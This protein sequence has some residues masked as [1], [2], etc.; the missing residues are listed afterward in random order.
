MSKKNWERVAGATY[1][2]LGGG[3]LYL[4]P[5]DV[6][7]IEVT[8]YSILVVWLFLRGVLLY[9][10]RKRFWWALGVPLIGH[11]FFLDAIAKFFPFDNLFGL[12]L[13]AIG[14]CLILWFA[15]AVIFGVTKT[16]P[17]VPDASLPETMKQNENGTT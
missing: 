2:V 8:F 5:G 13:G 17:P 7:W 14:E 9:R 16:N 3:L 12:F 15:A 6:V 1:A 10:R 11:I 4:L